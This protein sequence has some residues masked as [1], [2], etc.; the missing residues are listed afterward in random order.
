MKWY[1]LQTNAGH[2]NKV[3]T[4]LLQHLSNQGKSRHVKDIIAPTERITEVRDGQKVTREARLMPGYLLMLADLPLVYSIVKSTRGVRA[5]VGPGGEPSPLTQEEADRMLGRATAATTVKETAVQFAAG[6]VV[7]I[8]AG[9]LADFTG[10]VSEVDPRSQKLTVLVAIFG[11]TTPAE[12][13]WS[14]VRK[15]S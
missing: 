7:R 8:T 4:D 1:A 3:R 5:F 15:D 13:D 6:D 11:R 14:Q 9:P 12:V 10:E 2:E